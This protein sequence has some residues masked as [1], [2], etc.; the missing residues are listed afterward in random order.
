M[1]VHIYANCHI[2][3]LKL[4]QSQVLQISILLFPQRSSQI[5]Y[6]KTFYSNSFKHLSIRDSFCLLLKQTC[7]STNTH[8]HIYTVFVFLHVYT[9]RKSESWAL[10]SHHSLASNRK[11][12]MDFTLDIN[13]YVYNVSHFRLSSI[14]TVGTTELQCTK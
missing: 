7:E 12:I 9:Y 4:S 3:F 11:H 5:T 13:T 14:F 1:W 2:Y 10:K 8:A 6:C